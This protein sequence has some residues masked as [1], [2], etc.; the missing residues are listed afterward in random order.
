M[1]ANLHAVPKE[2]IDITLIY[3][4]PDVD[5]GTMSVQDIV[6]VLQGFSSAY[7]KLAATIDPNATHRLRIAGVKPGSAQIVLDV[8]RWLGENNNQIQAAS[9][10]VVGASAAVGVAYSILAKIVGVIH[11]KKHVQNRPFTERISAN[12][13]VVI[14]NSQNV[15]IEV[16]YDVFELFKGGLLDKDLERI[17]SPLGTGRIDAAEIEARTVD[18]LSL[19]ETITAE[20][21]PYFQT[22][23][24]PVTTSAP[25]WLL[26][27]LNSLVKSTDS[28]WLWL[29]DG[30]RAYYRYRGEDSQRLHALFG[31]Y[32]GPVRVLASANLDENL[33]I[34]SLDVYDIERGQGDLLA[35]L[36]I[37][38][39]EEEP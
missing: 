18:G 21:R 9:A 5:D 30:T 32:D 23:S 1:R 13:S 33:K 25:T 15:T 12:N 35:D 4:G 16:P 28:G 10:I 38:E 19:R 27:K 39:L 37:G 22:A 6:P 8:W 14:S 2:A 29:N 26:A 20:E 11:A 31:M 17:T 34:V 24:E 36:D 7:G 3:H